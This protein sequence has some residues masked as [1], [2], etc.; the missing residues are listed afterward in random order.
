MI[1]NQL[2]NQIKPSFLSRLLG[3]FRTTGL[4]LTNFLKKF[5][6]GLK[7]IPRLRPHHLPEMFENLSRKEFYTIAVCV[8]LILSAGGFLIYSGITSKSGDSKFGGELVEGLIGQPQFINPVLAPAR[9]VDT[10]LSR[11]VFAQLLKYDNQQNLVPD[12]AESLPQISSDQKTYTIK[13]KPNLKWQD[14]KPLTAEDVLFTIETIQDTTYDSPLRVNWSRVKAEKLDDLTLTF[15]LREVSVSFSGNFTFGILPRHIWE[16]VPANNFRLSDINLNAIGSGPF[17]VEE[18]QKTSD[19]TIKSITLKYNEYYHEGR[20][21]LDN[22]TFRFYADTD[23]LV[24]AFQAKKIQSFGYVPF[25]KKAYLT[26]SDK[27]SQYRINLPEYQAVF[28]NQSQNPVLADKAVRQALW[29][30]TDR[31]QIIDDVYLGFASESFGPILPGS[32]GYNENLAKSAHLSITEAVDILTRGGW[33]MDPA[34][35]LRTKNKKSLEFS[36]ATNNLPLNVKAAQTLQNQ[37][38]Q[39]GA[40]INL[41]IVSSAELQQDYIRPRNFDAL[42]F[43]ESTG[44]DQDP[45]SFWHSSQ[46]HDPG[47]NIS[48]FNNTEADKLLV[49][50]RRT[51]DETV[52]VRDYMRFQEIV[53]SELPAIF[54]VR[55]LYIYNVPKK[56]QGI[57]FE[58]L[59]FSSERFSNINQWYLAK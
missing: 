41:I 10:D 3:V 52:R 56:L 27:F 16:G 30:T 55:S 33:V 19:G 58:N 42:L 2:S 5:F 26:P 6:Q 38:S 25:D 9:N 37:W 59:A 32:L 49:E 15:K 53:N 51:N 20:P 50:A 54:V 57:N 23:E 22:L 13:L 43:S 36:L 12:L 35:G 18:I 39:I 17:K 1:E 4:V 47:L 11:I 29:L 24:N 7:L 14:G 46:S 48:E 8:L 44:G 40:K 31:K 28:F 45:F 21:Y 34:T